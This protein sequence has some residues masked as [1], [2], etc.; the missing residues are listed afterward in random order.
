MRKKNQKKSE[1]IYVC[2]T[3]YNVYITLLKEFG[4][5]KNSPNKGV[6]A[7]SLMSNDFRDLKQHLDKLCLFS[8]IIELN[9]VHPNYF[10]E[11]FKYRLDKS[12]WWNPF[13]W[14]INWFL[15]WRY[16][17]KQTSKH[18]NIDF[19]KYH[20]IFVYC[21]SDPIGQYLN[22]TRIKYI[23]VEDGLEAVR[24]NNPER[25]S[26]LLK[27][28]IILANLG[29]SFMR[30]GYSRYAKEVEVN[31]A[32]ELYSFGRNI[33][34][35]PRKELFNNLNNLEKEKIYNVFFNRKYLKT[36]DNE[37]KNA[38]ILAGQLCSSPADS[39]KIFHDII[40][41]YCTEYN[42]YIKPHPIDKIDYKKEFETCIVLERFFPLE[43]FNIKCDL[44][45]DRMISVT[46]VLDDY[47]FPKEK[48]RLGLKYLEKYNYPNMLTQPIDYHPLSK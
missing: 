11:K 20:Q 17:A 39:F 3:Y 14:Y 2:H 24:I 42:V 26:K 19:K 1:R 31:S 12:Y 41:E 36:F 40:K 33:T 4:F 5:Q 32:K 13:R 6:L 38:L 8:E 37:K 25:N 29:I 22:Y 27:L 16:I 28:K 18:I 30:D 34:E 10:E 43:I 9:E 46:T 44:K 21:D 35:V 23:A 45:I 15:Y 47:T 7:L 48:I